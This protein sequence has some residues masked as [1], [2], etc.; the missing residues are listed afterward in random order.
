MLPLVV[1][2]CL[3]YIL[4]LYTICISILYIQYTICNIYNIFP[5]MSVHP[6]IHLYAPCTSPIHF[7]PPIHPYTPNCVCP[8][9]L[10]TPCMSICPIP[11]YTP[12]IYMPPSAYTPMAMPPCPYTPM[13]ICSYVHMPPA[14]IYPHTS[15]CS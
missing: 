3:P 4:Y 6:L 13:S 12:Y 7:T 5:C 1:C 15:I 14:F 11:L 8:H 2:V 10:Y 9:S